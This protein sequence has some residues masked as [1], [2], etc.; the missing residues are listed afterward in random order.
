MA[1][2]VVSIPKS[3]TPRLLGQVP[4]AICHELDPGRCV[5][6]EDEVEVLGIRPEELERLFSD[7][8]DDITGAFRRGVDTVGIPVEI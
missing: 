7:A 4:E 8:I 5:G 6:D 2:F 1:V 3:T